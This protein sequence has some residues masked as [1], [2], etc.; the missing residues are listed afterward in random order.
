MNVRVPCY[1]RD[2]TIN[3]KSQRLRPRVSDTVLSKLHEKFNQDVKRHPQSIPISFHKLSGLLEKMLTFD[4]EIRYTATQCLNH[5]FF[6]DQREYINSYREEYPPFNI[7]FFNP[8]ISIKMRQERAYAVDNLIKI[9]NN[10][11]KDNGYG[12]PIKT[13]DW[14]QDRIM[15]QSLDIFDRFLKTLDYVLNEDTVE[16]YYSVCLYLSIKYFLTLPKPCEFKDLLSE[17]FTLSSKLGTYLKSAEEFEWHLIS[18]VLKYNIYR[19]TVYEAC[20]F[21]NVKL[22]E[23]KITELLTSYCTYHPE[24]EVNLFDYLAAIFKGTL[25]IPLEYSCF[26]NYQK[27]INSGNISPGQE[28]N[29]VVVRTDAV[30]TSIRG[31]IS[32]EVKTPQVNKSSIYVNTVGPDTRANDA[33]HTSR[34]LVSG[35]IG[36]QT[37]RGPIKFYNSI[38]K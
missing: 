38:R 9:Y 30:A 31:I 12:L 8:M 29:R 36:D 4:P 24:N 20:D 32:P 15:F 25:S 23:N 13:Y 6:S 34:A 33:P 27:V 7:S 18:N 21:F 37:A 16:L 11:S 22:D 2:W 28:N 14:Y 19:P 35:K 10:R 3:V 26:N 1:G 17:K 5:E